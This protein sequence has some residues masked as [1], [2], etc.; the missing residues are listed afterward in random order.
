MCLPLLLVG[1]RQELQV[2][3]REQTSGPQLMS[4]PVQRP[5]RHVPDKRAAGQ[6]QQQ[7]RMCDFMGFMRQTQP[8]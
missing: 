5:A 4:L 3:S 7:L 8:S 2:L 6:E 1:E